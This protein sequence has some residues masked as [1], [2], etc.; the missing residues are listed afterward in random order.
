MPKKEKIFDRQRH[1]SR[2]DLPGEFKFGDLGQLLFFLVFL[3]IWIADSFFLKFSVVSLDLRWMIFRIPLGVGILTISLW[4]ARSGL[5]V[6]FGEVREEPHVIQSGV[7]GIVRHPIYLGAILFY[8]G[9]LVFSFSLAAVVVWILVI[10]FY[11][12]LC[13]YEEKLLIDRFGD[14]YRTYMQKVPLL[15]PYPKRR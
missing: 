7:F 2:D 4:L 8:M 14:E 13:R 12:Y 6:V 10:G 5:E 1:Q 9:L 11:Y 15:F 3:L